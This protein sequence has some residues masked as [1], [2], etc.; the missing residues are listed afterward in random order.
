[1]RACVTPNSTP[2]EA[3]DD[4]FAV[5][6]SKTRA[7]VGEIGCAS[8]YK[9]VHYTVDVKEATTDDDVY[10]CDHCATVCVPGNNCPGNCFD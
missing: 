5:K 1:M 8:P 9:L 3:R 10:V 4:N 7:S 2:P 6:C